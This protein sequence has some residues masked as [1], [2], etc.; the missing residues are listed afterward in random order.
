MPTDGG[1]VKK[2]EATHAHGRGVKPRMPTDGGGWVNKSASSGRLF[3]LKK[4]GNSDT[5][6]NMDDHWGRY[7]Q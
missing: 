1:W 2:G 4:E 7:S 3:S 5:C 6:C